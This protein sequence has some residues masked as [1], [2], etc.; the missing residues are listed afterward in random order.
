MLVWAQFAAAA[1]Q[2]DRRLFTIFPPEE[3]VASSTMEHAHTAP[4]FLIS[5]KSIP[6]IT[7]YYCT[8]WVCMLYP[9][10]SKKHRAAFGSHAPL[11]LQ[12][13]WTKSP[14]SPQRI[15]AISAATLRAARS[16]PTPAS[17]IIFGSSYLQFTPRVHLPNTGSWAY[18]Y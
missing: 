18:Y 10:R 9:V 3:E 14:S 13:E 7:Q 12:C 17:D 11:V 8:L 16:L 4:F 15:K 5:L 6:E 1:S 2:S